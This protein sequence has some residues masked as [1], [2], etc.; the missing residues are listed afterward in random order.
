M[1]L[2]YT[3]TLLLAVFFSC[4]VTVLASALPDAGSIL[5]QQQQPTRLPDRLPQP[6]T[7][8]TE[9]PPLTDSGIAVTVKGFKF[10]GITG[11]A[12]EAELQELLKDSMGK[13]LGLADLQQIASRVTSYLREKGFFLARAY[14]PKQDVTE[15]IIEIAVLGGR[16]DGSA[17]IRTKQPSRISNSILTKMFGSSVQ[18]GQ[19]LQNDKIERALLL[20]NDLPGINAKA[21]LERGSSYGTTKVLVDVNEGP[22]FSGGLSA[23]NFGNRYTGIWRGTGFVSINDPF[24]IGDQLGLTMIGAENLYQG[25]VD[26]SA[27]LL[28]CGLKGNIGFSSLYYKLGEELASLQADG[29][30]D[31]FSAG[32]SYPIIRSRTFSFWTAAT[33]EYRMLNDYVG[34]T[35]TKDRDL[36]AGTFELTS[37]SY[38]S[39][40]GGGLTSVRL[41]ATSGNVA[42]GNTSDAQNDAITAQTA[43]NYCKFNYSIARLQRIINNLS[44][45]GSANGQLAGSNLD[46]S[47]KFIL[48]GP[49]G[50]R[51]Y[52]VGEASGD[53]GHS[54]TVELRYDT[55]LPTRY[56]T[57]QLVGFGDAG[58][59]TLNK[60][61]WTN[62][63]ST[64]TNR[65]NY[66][67]AGSGIGIN[68]SKPGLCA[69]RGSWAHTIGDNPGRSTTGKDADNRNDDNR[70]W[71]QATVWF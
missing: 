33:Y 23:D 52:P 43:G 32:L 57:L 46:S 40:G 30:A 34:G 37:S 22:L 54:M 49:T 58:N 21:S 61:L 51:S 24:G 56:G 60:E 67:L 16:V 2:H 48:G 65:N 68:Y 27:Q 47:E 45:F 15:G 62:A 35:L 69:L 5:R 50:V 7:T 71:L 64:A 6:D 53:E 44:L 63:V 31:T 29:H 1:R 8:E 28:P 38:D 55:P 10:S 59:I 25:K 20:T 14:L 12:T 11:M 19:A 39:L 4:T 36:H 41:A 26:Y 18:N 42:L 3:A 70:F 17:V 13:R 66:W 9:R